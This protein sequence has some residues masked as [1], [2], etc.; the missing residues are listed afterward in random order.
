MEHSKR[1]NIG[2]S[3]QICAEQFTFLIM[4]K[5]KWKRPISVNT[6][7]NIK[8]KSKL[9][10]RYIQSI[11]TQRYCFLIK[12]IRNT[13]TNKTRQADR[14]TQNEIAKTCKNNPKRSGN[15]LRLKQKAKTPLGDLKYTTESGD[16][17]IAGEDDKKAEVLCDF[18]QV[19]FVLRM[20]L[21][22]RY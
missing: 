14:F 12:K 21:F 20:I 11:E 13:V 16:K 15:M 5:A 19:Y 9:W 1:E 18:F 7:E 17:V 6:R 10:K 22:F 4:E 3:Q 2:R 8:Q